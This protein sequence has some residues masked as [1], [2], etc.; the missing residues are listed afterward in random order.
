MVSTGRRG[1]PGPG[2]L[3]NQNNTVFENDQ[4]PIKGTTVPNF[5][6]EENIAKSLNLKKYVNFRFQVIILDPIL[7]K[8]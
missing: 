3:S 4:K 1:R 5:M 6:L 2:E 7:D 8:S